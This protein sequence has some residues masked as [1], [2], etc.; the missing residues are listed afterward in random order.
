VEL[1]WN[2]DFLVGG[3]LTGLAGYRFDTRMPLHLRSLS[4]FHVALPPLLLWLLRRLGYDHRALLTQTV[5]TWVVLPATYR[6]TDCKE[7]VNWAFGPGGRRRP[8][9]RA[10]STWAC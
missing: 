4:L 9:F 8:S 7:N 3:R 1:G 6:L 10:R 5:L 2:L